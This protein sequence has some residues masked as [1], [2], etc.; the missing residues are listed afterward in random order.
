MKDSQFQTAAEKER[1]LRDWE[2]F[3]KSGLKQGKF[4]KL[5]YRHLEQHCSFIAHFDR[6]GFFAIY[7]T[8]G[9][10]KAR[11][12]SQFDQRNAK[13]DGIPPG[14]EYGDTW[15]CRGDYEDINRR[16]VSIATPY[17]PMLLLEAQ[18]EQKDSDVAKA[19]ALLARHGISLP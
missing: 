3:L 2:S 9:D 13:A 5:L 11:F 19:R 10:G 6:A 8:S 12:L 14:W 7:F 15:W 4:T 17:I 18:A 16:M 1:V